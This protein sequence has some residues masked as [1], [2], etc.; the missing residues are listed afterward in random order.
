[1]FKLCRETLRNGKLGPGGF[2]RMW[3][4]F[5][6][7]GLQ[8]LKPPVF[9]VITSVDTPIESVTHLELRQ[10]FLGKRTSIQ[11]IELYPIQVKADD[12]LRQAFEM[13][14]FG[15]TFDVEEYRVFQKLKAGPD[16]P[17]TVSGWGLVM[18]YVAKN[19]GYLGYVPTEQL[20]HLDKT[21]LKI[22][23]LQP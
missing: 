2:S 17:L 15:A 21:K 7:L 13:Q 9:V 14:V 3:W 20:N 23:A 12:P 10:L 4:V 16:P 19:P 6:L 8:Q 22:V 11:Q 5:L 18:A 1:M